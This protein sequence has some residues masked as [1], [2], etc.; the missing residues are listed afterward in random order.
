VNK[1][2]SETVQL[3]ARCDGHASQPRNV[4]IAKDTV[5]MRTHGCRNATKC[6]G[7]PYGHALC[8]RMIMIAPH[9]CRRML[10]HPLNTGDGIHCVVHHV[11]QKE[12]RIESFV[13]GC[14]CRPVGVDISK[15]QDPHAQ[16]PAV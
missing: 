7:W 15:Q 13:D 3:D 8:D 1:D 10:P 14:K 12:A 9:D 4:F 11:T 16:A 6:T 5:M 2:E